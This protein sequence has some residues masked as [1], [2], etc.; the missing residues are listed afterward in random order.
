MRNKL[1]KA[2]G[3]VAL[4]LLLLALNVCAFAAEPAVDR[5]AVGSI[6]I[7]PRSVDGDHAVI[8]GTAFTLYR[9]AEVTETDGALSYAL[10]EAFSGS[11]ADLSDLEAQG[12]S[13]TL[14]A[15]ADAQ[16]CA[17][18]AQE[19]DSAG[20]V[21]FSG[22]ALGVYLL[23][24]TGVAEGSYATEPFLVSVP[25][26]AS[27]G[28]GWVYDV[29]ASP[30]AEMYEVTDV[31]VRKLWND[32]GD[33]ASR[34]ASITVNLYRGDVLED[35]V[36]LTAETGWTHTWKGLQKSDSYSVTEDRL[37]DYKATYSAE[38]TVLTITNTP[39]L[40]YTGQLNWPIPL[41][42]IGGLV[43]FAVG[44]VLAFGKRKKRKD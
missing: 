16:Q 17:G 9:V 22:L 3:S 31:T 41:L 23:V 27:D 28:T 1:L 39:A 35:T 6:S 37:K 7:T 29:D 21:T 25:Q 34:P 8:L 5:D 18:A 42:A 19:A 43:L 2:A 38:G 10:T 13:R 36:T 11:G 15:Y 24:Q 30:K 14:A 26:A 20:T 4:A 32:G 12:L 33:E 40:P 44:W